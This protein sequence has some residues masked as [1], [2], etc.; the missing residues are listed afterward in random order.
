MVRILTNP[1]EPM[2]TLPL[3]EVKAN[4]SGLIDDVERRDEEIVVT[5]NGRPAAVIVSPEEY[6]S[7]K[8]TLA[9]R[10]DRDL[11]REIRA[12]L[13]ALKARKTKL[14]TLQELFK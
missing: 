4:L 9:V 12:G 8:E 5:K 10:A 2:K 3:S 11:M 7:W 1:W 6:E 14:Y 13:A